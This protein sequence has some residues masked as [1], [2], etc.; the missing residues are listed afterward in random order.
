MNSGGDSPARTLSPAKVAR[1]LGFTAEAVRQW[2]NEPGDPCPC[3]VKPRAGGKSAY[4]FNVDEVRAWR[5]RRAR[6][7]YKPG[8]TPPPTPESPCAPAHP[9]DD[10]DDTL[11]AVSL[12][13]DERLKRVLARVDGILLSLG[14][15]ERTAQELQAMSSALSNLN[16]TL[17]DMVEDVR[18]HEQEAGQLL[19]APAAQRLVNAAG[20]TLRGEIERLPEDA[21]RG[22][23][24]ELAR[25]GLLAEGAD[26]GGAVER[27]V[28]AALR[29]HV[30]R[31]L[32]A[33]AQAAEKCG[34]DL[35]AALES[36]KAAA[37]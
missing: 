18:E 10:K 15:G 32:L 22:V 25:A 6:V 27:L 3:T 20:S 31:A 37:A 19:P 26:G 29:P 2:A 24:D 4:L 23:A 30:E 11:F 9:L 5:E 35:R 14:S 36:K 34:E 28:R 16:R 7:V 12:D 13:P 8:T 21:A 17:R 33:A 1:L